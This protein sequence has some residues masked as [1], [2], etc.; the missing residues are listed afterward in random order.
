MWMAG[1]GIQGGM[2][3]GETDDF[4]YNVT[5]NPVIKAWDLVRVTRDKYYDSIVVRVF[6]ESLDYTI[7]QESGKV[8]G[9]SKKSPRGYSEYWTLIRG[10]SV[11]GT[12]ANPKA[13]PSCAAE[14][15]IS[16]GGNCEY[17]GTHVTAGEFDWV[18]SKIEQDEAYTG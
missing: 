4:S 11:R 15:A 12:P 3:Y 6:A 10:A 1:G 16:M 7:E 17:C 9:G 2:T 8:V 18:L 13:C 14:L 5:E